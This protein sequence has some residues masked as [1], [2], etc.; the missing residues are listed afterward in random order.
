MKILK[1][2]I[3]FLVLCVLACVTVSCARID[4]L[5]PFDLPFDIGNG[6]AEEELVFIPLPQIPLGVHEF[7]DNEAEE[8]E[9]R[10]PIIRTPSLGD[11]YITYGYVILNIGNISSGYVKIKHGSEGVSA[12][13]Q[14]YTL[15]CPTPD[16]FSIVADGE[17]DVF[18][19]T[20]GDGVYTIR[21]L[22]LYNDRMFDVVLAVQVDVRIGDPH[23]PF[24]YPS[25]YVNFNADSEA[26][27]FASRVAAMAEDDF[28]LVYLI[29]EAVVRNINFDES[30]ADAIYLGMVTE[31]VPNIDETLF[32]R[33]GICFDFSALIAAML[34]SQGIPTRLE[35]GYVRGIFHAWVAVYVPGADWR[36]AAHPSG[37]GWGLLD[38]TTTSANT[39]QGF[40]NPVVNVNDFNILF[41]R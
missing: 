17:W 36:N 33:R 21:V 10:E 8:F 12:L 13:V 25:R 26:V 7:G 40:L 2:G 27:I 39:A 6:N 20:R 22:E 3:I 14:I 29:Y 32:T 15:N 31:H 23:S 41:V 37:D 28:H 11:E 18:A 19:L 24:L 35:I 4:D 30:L 38:P 34:R 9:I 16:V 5:L 1:L